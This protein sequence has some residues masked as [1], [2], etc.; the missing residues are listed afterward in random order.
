ML[1][2]TFGVSH[3]TGYP[4]F[5]L[6]G[7]VFAHLPLGGDA[8]FR[9][10]VFC[11]L[12]GAA[13]G[14]LCCLVLREL[15]VSRATAL[16]AA[17]LLVAAPRLWVYAASA[18]VYP[19][20]CALLLLAVWVLLRWAHGTT[21]LWV[22]GLVL[23]LG[24]CHHVSFRLFGLPAL[25]F[26]LAVEPRLPL[27][28]RRWLPAA[29]CLLL[30][31][32]L[33]AYVP[34]SAA[35]YLAQPAWQGDILGVR[36][37]VAGGVVSP[38]FYGPGGWPALVLISGYSG[39]LLH[40]ADLGLRI[41]GQY[42]V[43]LRQQYPLVALP[44]MLV[45][46]WTLARRDGKASLLLGLTYVV[47]LF[48]ALKYLA[49]VGEDGHH[50]IPTYLV[51]AIWF[52]A[53]ADQLLSWAQAVAARAARREASLRT[54][55]RGHFAPL[56][57]GRRSPNGGQDARSSLAAL[58]VK[59]ARLMPA[60]VLA[61]VWAA[62]LYS[63]AVH[64]PVAAAAQQTDTGPQARAVLMGGM[65]QGAVLAGQWSDVTPLRYLQRVEGVRPDL[66]VIHTDATGIG[67]LAPQAIAERQPFFVLRD[68]VA[69]YRVLPL[70]VWGDPVIS[71]RADLR[72]NG[73]V[74]WLGFD[75]EGQGPGKTQGSFRPGDVLS[76]TLY[77][78][79]SAAPG[80]DWSTF[81]HLL[82][83]N[84]DKKAQVDRVPLEGIYPPSRWQAGL[85]LADQYELQLPPSLAPGRYH[86]IFGAYRGNDRFGWADGQNTEPLTDVDVR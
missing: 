71:H 16:A 21:P 33:Y 70:P 29:A 7:W 54:E 40:S 80:Q 5:L 24:L 25:A 23:G 72:L 30:P 60:V 8:A 65:P 50:F 81:I 63:L 58:S 46:V 41:L 49:D 14:A 11:M 6:L 48:F 78:Q 22:V 82:D 83:G 55:D 69:G 35:R 4:L 18:S 59:T 28:P 10:T 32:A 79:T 84:G 19:L 15:G 9:V 20:A 51:M 17:L 43:E 86:L 34:L 37:V 38:F 53:G 57:A 67:W 26:M 77:W 39:Q 62:G 66:W 44:V 75:L 64:W 42:S 27:R 61:A 13:T 36:K 52:G 3:P 73:A 31:L 2:V 1:S 47:T 56:S 74:S 68:T 76:L 12:C 85:T 45:G